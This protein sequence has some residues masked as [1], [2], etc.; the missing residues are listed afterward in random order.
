MTTTRFAQP[1]YAMAVAGMIVLLTGCTPAVEAPRV[2]APPI[3]SVQPGP[4]DWWDSA[5]HEERADEDNL[6][7]AFVMVDPNDEEQTTDYK[8]IEG[9]EADDPSEPAPIAPNGNIRIGVL[10][11][12]KPLY[13]QITESYVSTDPEGKEA[14]PPM[15]CNNS[16]PPAEQGVS[17]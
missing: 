16:K 3:A 17:N 4:G 6:V 5:E 13:R 15:V 14:G 8:R 7:Q 1:V 12:S 11:E 9:N 2:T 10:F